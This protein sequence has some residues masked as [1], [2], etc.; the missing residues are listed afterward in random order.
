MTVTPSLTHQPG[1][2][3][4][5]RLREA[6]GAFPSGVVAVAAPGGRRQLIGLAAQLVHLGEHRARRWCPSRSPTRRRPGRRCAEAVHLGITVLADHHGEVCRQLAGPR[7]APLRRPRRQVTG[8]GAVLLD[9]AVATYDCPCPRGR[10][11]RPRH[12]AARG[13]EVGGERRAP[14][15]VPPLLHSPAAPRRPRPLR[16]DGRING[17]EVDR[18]ARPAGGLARREDARSGKHTGASPTY[19]AAR[20]RSPRPSAPPSSGTTS[21][22]TARPPALVFDK[23]YFNGL[24]GPAAQFAAF[25]TFA[26]GFF[27][28]PIGGLIFGHF[29][30]RIGRKKMLLLTLLIMGVGT[31]AHRPAADLRPDRRLGADRPGA[32]CGSCRASASAASTAAPCCWPSSTPPRERARLLRQLRP[33]RRTR[34]AAAGGRR[35]LDRRAAARRGVPRLGLARLLPDQHR[36]ARRSA[37]TSASRSWRPRRSREVQEKKEVSRIPLRDLLREAAEAAAARHGHPLH[38]GLH[39]QPVLRLPA[40]LRRDQPRAAASRGP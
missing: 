39:L 29:G 40:G 25:A 9:E 2:R 5:A 28:R 37:P 1:P 7:R 27:A 23:L 15:R 18:G 22:S 11:R 13:H 32:C 36:A 17:A 14:A 16:L 4:A 26:V 31:A 34:R 33:H 38:R 24:D 30:D 19:P 20:S 6:F 3:P 12:R 35:L 21:S 10:R 8:N